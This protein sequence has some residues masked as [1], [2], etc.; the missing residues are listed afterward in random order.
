MQPLRCE[1]AQG[2]VSVEETPAFSP[3][4]GTEADIPVVPPPDCLCK[5][6]AN[7][8][9]YFGLLGFLFFSFFGGG[10]RGMVVVRQQQQ[11]CENILMSS[12]NTG[13]EEEAQDPGDVGAAE[14]VQ[15]GDHG[16]LRAAQRG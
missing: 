11:S 2:K 5:G 3:V 1:E 7:I 6:K 9:C 14:A 13:T 12:P 15:R 10:G 4:D 16:L 8:N